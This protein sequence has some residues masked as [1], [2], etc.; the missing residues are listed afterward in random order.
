MMNSTNCSSGSNLYWTQVAGVLV[1]SLTVHG[2][3]V[4]HDFGHALLPPQEHTEL[5]SKSTGDID[6]YGAGAK[7][8][9]GGST[10]SSTSLTV[11]Y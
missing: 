7:I 5:S 4:Q 1:V 2:V 8:G 10:L 11:H 6:I 9:G 3:A